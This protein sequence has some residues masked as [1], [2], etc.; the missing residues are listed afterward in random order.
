MNNRRKRRIFSPE[1]KVEE[2]KLV[3]ELEYSIAQACKELDLGETALR[4]WIEQVE[5]E[6]H[7]YY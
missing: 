2:V 6:S 1:F 4:R 3:T 7:G 5:V